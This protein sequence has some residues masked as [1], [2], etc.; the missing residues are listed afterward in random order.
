M[1]FNC[2]KTEIHKYSSKWGKKSPDGNLADCQVYGKDQAEFFRL[3]AKIL[4]YI[5]SGNS[6][7]PFMNKSDLNPYSKE[8]LNM[9][10]QPW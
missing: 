4:C 10:P 1:M 8:V 3:Y 6:L 2:C 7:V 5:V 9:R